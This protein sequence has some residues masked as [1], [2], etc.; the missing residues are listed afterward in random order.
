MSKYNN[1]KN[2][3]R[4]VTPSSGIEF[5]D[6]MNSINTPTSAYSYTDDK[7]IE[8]QAKQNKQF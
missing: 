1:K 2:R 4:G 8:E 6:S 3:T 5:P 7:K